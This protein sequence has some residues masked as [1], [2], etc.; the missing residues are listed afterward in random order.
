MLDYEKE[1]EDHQRIEVIKDE[2]K[3]TN[4]ERTSIQEERETIKE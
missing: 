3:E 1:K 4:K 2:E